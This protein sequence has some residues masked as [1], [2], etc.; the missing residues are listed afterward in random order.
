VLLPKF[1]R[2]SAARGAAVRLAR[3]LVAAR[4]AHLNCFYGYR[5][6]KISIRNQKTRWGSCSRRGNLSF[7]YRLIYLPPAHQDYIIAHELCHLGQFNHSKD[8]W[9]LVAHAVPNAKLIRKELRTKYV[10]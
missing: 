9:A 7:N 1:R 4:I 8:F 2:G 5:I 10:L 6:G 3:I